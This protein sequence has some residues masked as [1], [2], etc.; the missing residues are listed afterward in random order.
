MK[1]LVV[2]QFE[3]CNIF[4]NMFFAGVLIFLNYNVSWIAPINPIEVRAIEVFP[5]QL[6]IKNRIYPGCMVKE[7]IIII[8]NISQYDITRE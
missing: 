1:I 4:M 5:T 6:E 3:N 2:D 8:K 7:D